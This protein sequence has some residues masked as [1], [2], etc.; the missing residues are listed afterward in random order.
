MSTTN[1]ATTNPPPTTP[2]PANQSNANLVPANQ[3]ATNQSAQSSASQTSGTVASPAQSFPPATT[4][5]Q[6]VKLLRKK[7]C[8]INDESFCKKVLSEVT[9]FQ[10]CAYLPFLNSNGT[11]QKTVFEVIYHIFLFDQKLRHILFEIIETI[12]LYLRRQISD[13]HVQKYGPLGYLNAANFSANHDHVLFLQNVQEFINRSSSSPEIR[14]QLASYGGNLP[15]W[16]FF[17]I[18]TLGALAKF[19]ADLDIVDQRA[20]ALK[21]YNCSPRQLRSWFK[22]CS[23]LRNRCA[24]ASRLYFKNLSNIPLPGPGMQANGSTLYDGILLLKRL[25]PDVDLWNAKGFL[26]I[27]TLVEENRQYITLSHIGFPNN[28]LD[29]LHN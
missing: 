23:D 10:L 14:H 20:I 1:Q 11:Y 16:A 17:D 6:Q 25:Y 18:T 12:E 4:V 21:L 2:T 5:N 8:I 15:L 22:C 19:Y 13:Y 7:N 27:A 28:W 3:A 26:P 9:Y 24:H 29:S